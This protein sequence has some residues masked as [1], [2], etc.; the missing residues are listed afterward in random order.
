MELLLRWFIEQQIASI[1]TKITT[2]VLKGEQ[3]QQH[4]QSVCINA[5][6]ILCLDA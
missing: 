1:Q 3:H 2:T 5:S 6:N 4:A